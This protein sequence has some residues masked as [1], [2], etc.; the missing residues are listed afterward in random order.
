MDFLEIYAKHADRYDELVNAEDVDAHLLPAIQAVTPLQGESILEVGV[1]TGRITRLLVGAGARVVGFE[2]SPAMLEVARKHLGAHGDG[3][4]L[5]LGDAQSLPV[6]SGWAS[7][8]IA[9]WVFGHFRYWMPQD[10]RES[11][12]RAISEMRRAL[13]PGGALIIIE[14]LGTGREVPEPPNPALAEYY[15]WLENELG[16]VRGHLRTDYLFD[17]VDQ[18]ADVTGFFFGEAFGALVRE[19][20]WRRIPECTGLWSRRYEDAGSR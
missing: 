8:A 6:E 18:A 10:W 11:I 13:R 1:G 19:R 12:G 16:L 20:A 7:A 17:S 2:K 3:C 14:T 5:E 15:D 4:R 9:G